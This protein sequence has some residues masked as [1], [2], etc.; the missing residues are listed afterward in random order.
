METV[1]AS[2]FFVVSG[3]LSVL[4]PQDQQ[5]IVAFMNLLD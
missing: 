5:D 4:T 1:Y 2:F 3:G